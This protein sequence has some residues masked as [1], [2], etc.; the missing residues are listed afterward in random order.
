METRTVVEIHGGNTNCCR[1]SRWRN[2]LAYVCHV[3]KISATQIE[4]SSGCGYKCSNDY[5]LPSKSVLIYQK[6]G[7]PPVMFTETRKG[8]WSYHLVQKQR[9]CRSLS[10]NVIAEV[11]LIAEEVK[12]G[13]ESGRHQNTGFPYQI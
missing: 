1:N 9:W 7:L 13:S 6:L 2:L 12:T 11:D 3:L 8:M 10:S 5:S 4:C